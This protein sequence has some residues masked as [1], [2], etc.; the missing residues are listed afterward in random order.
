MTVDLPLLLESWVLAL[1]AER[2]SPRTVQSYSEG[3]RQYIAWCEETGTAAALDRATVNAWAAHMLDDLGR[4]ATTVKVRVQAV[5][6]FAAWL[7][8]EGEIAADPLV[9]VK[10][11]KAR[12]QGRRTA[13][14]RPD[15]RADQGLPGQ[16]PARPPG[17][18]NRPA[19]G[20]DGST[21]RR[22]GRHGGG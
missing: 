17:R 19:H 16:E 2:L 21:G 8:D 3:V 10:A 12:F 9:G 13:D 6:Q 18:G 14:R 22:G 20:G 1:R 4:E 7:A 11:P 5:R 15:S